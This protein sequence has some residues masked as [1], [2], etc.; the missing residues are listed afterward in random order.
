MP[1]EKTKSFNDVMPKIEFHPDL[2]KLPLA[3]VLGEVYEITD[4]L[5]VEGFDSQFGKS[6]FALLLLT[7]LKEGKQYTTLA[8]GIVVVK[9]VRYALD[10][11]LLPLFGTVTYNGTYYDIA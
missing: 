10:H 2:P 7:D 1:K 6:D 11:K 3:D 8:G 5:I 9:K 4:A